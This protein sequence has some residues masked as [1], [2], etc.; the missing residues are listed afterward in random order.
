[1][2]DRNCLVK[3]TMEMPSDQ[4]KRLKSICAL[5]GK[6]LKEVVNDLIKVFINA[7]EKDE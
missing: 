1:M 6:T 5:S 2:E 4:H 3:V 7:V